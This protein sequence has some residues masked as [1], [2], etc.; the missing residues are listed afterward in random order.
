MVTAVVE[1]LLKGYYLW[2]KNEICWFCSR[3]YYR[4][5][6]YQNISN[7]MLYFRFTGGNEDT[8]E[9][10]FHV[11]IDPEVEAEL[12]L[13]HCPRTE[14]RYLHWNWTKFGDVSIQ[15]CPSGST[16][17]ARWTCGPQ[18]GRPARG[19]V[20]VNSEFRGEFWRGHQPDMSDC[21]STEMSK[22]EM[23]VR[24]QDPENVL[25]SKL[26][27]LTNNIP[28]ESDAIQSSKRLFGGDLE[29]SVAVMKSVANRLQ[30]LLQQSQH[31]L[32]NR[33]SYL[34]EVFQ[35]IF[36]AA[37]N[38]LA[39][40]RRDAWNDL[41]RGQRIKVASSLMNILEDHAFLLADVLDQPE[42]VTE[43]TRYA[44]NFAPATF[45]IVNIHNS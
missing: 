9:E 13:T 28:P 17:L 19:H 24:E 25:A 43:S 10:N 42:T 14:A 4:K 34:Q 12:R 37:S 36:R 31:S 3:I 23:R 44:G 15:P 21:K 30:Y 18:K 22:L 32:Y 29:A 45:M 11:E 5:R 38:L 27:L 2:G 7:E 20:Q 35:N 40:E 41:S 39:P 33:E 8:I 6:I 16:G 1:K 26:A